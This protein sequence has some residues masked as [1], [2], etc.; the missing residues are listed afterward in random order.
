MAR[1][2]S[3][4]DTVEN[5]LLLNIDCLVYAIYI[6]TLQI[7]VIFTLNRELACVSI[8]GMTPMFITMGSYGVFMQYYMRKV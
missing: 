2:A 5:A 6:L 3:D 7:I 1:M 4:I 8:I